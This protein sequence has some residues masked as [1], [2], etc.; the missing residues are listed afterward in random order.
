MLINKKISK[1]DNFAYLLVSLTFLLFSSASVDQ[2]TADGEGQYW[3]IM[4]TIIT[5]MIGIWSVRSTDYLFHTGLGLILAT[6]V[7]SAFIHFLDQASL[8]FIHIMLLLFFLL[9]TLKPAIEQTLFS[10]DITANNMRGSICIFLLLGLIWTML[11]LLLLEFFPD[12]F[13]GI[14]AVNWK[15]NLPDVIYFSFVTIT[16]LGFGDILPISSLARFFVYM[17][18]VIGIFYM[19]VVVSSLVG[20]KISDS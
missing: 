3:V 12:S 15:Q 13:S 6:I 4:A 11:Y 16:T 17:E 10:G 20:A 18:S 5:M 7:I 8:E 1:K 9:L 14:D 19:A 2:F